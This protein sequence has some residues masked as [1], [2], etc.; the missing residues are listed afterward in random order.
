MQKVVILGAWAS[1]T[2]AM[3]G[4]LERMGYYTCPSHWITYDERTPIS[5][6]PNALRDIVLPCMEEAELTTKEGL[7]RTALQKKLAAWSEA[8]EKKAEQGGWRG[9][10]I[11]LPHLAFFLPEVCAAWDP[12]FLVMTRQL[13]AIETTRKRRAW[14]PYLGAA[15]AK[16]IYNKVFGDLLAL[17]RSYLTVAFDELRG[18]PG[19]E[20][21]RVAAFIG[22]QPGAYDREKALAWVR[23]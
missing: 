15:G 21:D 6:G 5:Y 11:K 10:A 7:D 19:R 23:R 12:D 9:L 4:I 17:Q 1:G 22:L 8:E 18:E 2:S 16:A 20:I 14:Q 13:N 3:A